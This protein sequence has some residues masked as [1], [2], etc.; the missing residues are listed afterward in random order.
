MFFTPFVRTLVPIMW[1]A[2]VGWI[3]SLIPGLEPVRELLLDQSSSL[4]LF[5][6]ALGAAG[7]YALTKWLEPK[8]PNW[9]SAIL[10]GSAKTP[11]YDEP[12]MH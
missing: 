6:L 12:P 5:V 8:L 9:L 7:W 4:T 10:M 2:F 11:N 3:L 1:S